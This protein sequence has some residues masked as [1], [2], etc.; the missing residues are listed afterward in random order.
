MWLQNIEGSGYNG[1]N[2]G[3][4]NG[5]PVI[6]QG[7]HAFMQVFLSPREPGSVKV[8]RDLVCTEPAALS[9]Q[10]KTKF[11]QQSWNVMD[12]IDP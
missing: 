9:P 5:A 8:S 1:Q 11:E 4:R 7:S 6:S 2:G 10:G 3:W 12:F